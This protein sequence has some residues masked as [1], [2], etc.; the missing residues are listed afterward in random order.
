[1]TLPTFKPMELQQQ[2]Q[3]FDHPD[4]MFEI[5]YD[6]FRAL[7][8][9]EDGQCQLVSRND[10]QYSRFADLRNAVISHAAGRNK[11]LHR[12]MQDEIELDR[13]TDMDLLST[14]CGPSVAR[15]FRPR[16]GRK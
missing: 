1:M 12:I 3:S 14:G 6:G 15:R 2:K 5:K 13:L 10:H 7:A 16:A 8:Y 9:V 11:T 4:W